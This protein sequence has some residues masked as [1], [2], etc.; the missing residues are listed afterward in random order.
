MQH[1]TLTRPAWRRPE[2]APAPST[3]PGSSWVPALLCD[4]VAFGPLILMLFL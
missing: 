4:L 1:T 2:A 3:E